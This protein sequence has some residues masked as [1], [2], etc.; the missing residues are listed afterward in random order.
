MLNG[1]LGVANSVTCPPVVVASNRVCTRLGEPDVVV[2]SLRNGHGL[3]AIGQANRP[4]L[5]A[6]QVDAIDAVAVEL[7]H[8][9]IVIGAKRD[10]LRLSIISADHAFADAG[11]EWAA[12]DDAGDP[13]VGI[14]L[15]S[16]TNPECAVGSDDER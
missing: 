12:Q 6:P 1:A 11:A 5:T 3:S 14:W 4:E 10:G 2:R 7:G 9:E 15:A 8:P 16:F 13:A